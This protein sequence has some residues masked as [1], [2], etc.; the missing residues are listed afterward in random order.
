MSQFLGSET[1]RRGVR[2]VFGLLQEQC[3]NRRLVHALLEAGVRQL[4]P[5]HQV[6][7]DQLF[8]SQLCPSRSGRHCTTHKLPPLP[9]LYA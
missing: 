8:A 5:Q 4:L 9:F 6:Q 1:T 2:R 7:L 3:L